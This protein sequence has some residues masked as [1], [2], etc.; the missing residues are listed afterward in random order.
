MGDTR[1]GVKEREDGKNG[2]RYARWNLKVQNFTTR[3]RKGEKERGGGGKGEG[4]QFS[5]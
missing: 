2:E 3:G 4:E 5:L 1:K